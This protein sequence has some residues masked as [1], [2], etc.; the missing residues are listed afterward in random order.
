MYLEFSI[1]PFNTRLRDNFLGGF[2]L[3]PSLRRSS[4]TRMRLNCYQCHGSLVEIK[5]LGDE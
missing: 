4:T 2:V 1:V 5:K 3:A